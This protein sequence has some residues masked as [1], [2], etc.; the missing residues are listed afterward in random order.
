MSDRWRS[1][2]SRLLDPVLSLAERIDRR[3]RGIRAVRAEGLLGLE[4]Q[5]WG[6][7][8]VSLEDGARVGR[9]DLIG[10]MHVLGGRATELGQPGWQAPGLQAG[11]A[12]LRALASWAATRPAALRPVAYHGLT[13][14]AA[15]PRREG[16]QISPRRRTLRARLDEWYMR[17]L[18]ARWSREGR[19][20]LQRGHGR[21]ESV[22]I[23]L[24]AAG[25]Q[26]RYGRPPGSTDPATAPDPRDGRG[27][28]A[29]ERSSARPRP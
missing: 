23:W 25:L 3:R 18:L 4:L 16:W 27:R 17:W 8:E 26:A 11:H 20:R 5:R 21:L 15:F 2:P 28:P 13:I 22:E 9:G 10:E 19:S 24:S 1:A 14:H 6:G 7:P 12:D 29:T